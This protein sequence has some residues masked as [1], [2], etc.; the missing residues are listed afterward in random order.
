MKEIDDLN[1]LINDYRNSIKS[2]LKKDE[3]AEVDAYIDKINNDLT[4][5]F[6]FLKK[7]NKDEK[8]LTELKQ[9]LDTHMREKK[10]LEKH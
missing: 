2:E 4:H 6:S 10:W 8:I 5:V 1:E 9:K 7:M 3:L